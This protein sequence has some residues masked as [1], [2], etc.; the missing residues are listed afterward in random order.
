MQ[1]F[2]GCQ[3]N[4]HQLKRVDIDTATVAAVLGRISILFRT[5]TKIQG[6]F[7]G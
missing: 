6:K 2:N 4:L 5:E 1:N 7:C 3:K